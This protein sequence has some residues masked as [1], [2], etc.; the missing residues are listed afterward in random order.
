MI[1]EYFKWHYGRGFT[2]LITLSRNF[3]I[4]FG[5]FFSLKLL[6][7]TLFSPWKRMGE[8]YALGFHIESF[9]STLLINFVMRAV[10]FIERSVIIA[11]G[12][13]LI[14]IFLILSFTFSILWL[15]MPFLL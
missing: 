13:F 14:S 4:F 7:S 6:F 11:I 3:T 5:H 9:L 15:L 2:E 1:F 12:L 10:G 8:E